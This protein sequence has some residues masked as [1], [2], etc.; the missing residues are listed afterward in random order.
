MTVTTEKMVAGGSCIARIEGKAVFVPLSLPGETLE[1]EITDAKKDYSFA[2]VISVLEPSEHRVEPPCP[3]F[4]KCG[5]CSLQMA[6]PD[7]QRELRLSILADTLS[8]AHVES[9]KGIHI[10]SGS[11]LEYRSRFQFHRTREGGIGLREGSSNTVVPIRDCPVAVPAIR[12]ALADGSLAREARHR[13]SGDRFHVFG[14]EDRIWQEEGDT[15]CAVPLCGKNVGFDVRGFFQ[16]NIPMLERLITAIQ[17]GPTGLE[18]GFSGERLLDFYSGVGTFSAV[19]GDAFAETVLVEHNRE[20]LDLA[21]KNLASRAG[22]ARFCPVSDEDWH[23]RNESRLRYDSAIVD[24]P[25]QGIGKRALE[26]FSGSGIADI[27]SVSCDPVTFARDASKLVASGFRLV[28]VALYDF[29]PQTH[30][31]ET[32]AFFTR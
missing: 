19:A 16:S 9:E 3:L 11:P 20:A 17:S 32:L 6:D 21:R 30:H 5:G 22:I 27:R 7:Y 24:P 2:R 18:G 8:R 31:I 4:G 15:A 14:F 12:K 28:D 23:T 1:I 13:N 29:Y 25:R 26:W 10:E